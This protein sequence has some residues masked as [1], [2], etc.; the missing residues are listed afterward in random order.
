MEA[1]DPEISVCLTTYNRARF[2]NQTLDSLLAQTFVDFELIIADDC[3]TDETESVCI[4]YVETDRRVRYFRNETNLRMPANLNFAISQAKGKYIANLHDGDIFRADLLEKWKNALERYPSAG[5]VFNY[6]EQLDL[7]GNSV[8][9][10]HRLFETELISGRDLVKTIYERLSSPVW[11][12]VMARRAVYEEIGGFDP[13]YGP[14]ADVDMWIRI[15]FKYDVACILEPL[16]GLRAR[17]PECPYNKMRWQFA[18]SQEH[19]YCRYAEKLATVTG[20]KK[21]KLISNYFRRWDYH[22]MRLLAADV[23]HRRWQELREGVVNFLPE[24]AS[25]RL[26]KVGKLLTRVLSIPQK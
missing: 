2:L 25:P 8:G 11:G 17:E 20:L 5:F 13:A 23:Y 26:N 6:Y 18:I 14:I 21:Q 1:R 3:S 12:T 22:I 9:K 15:A 19:M 10:I 4:K 7:D 24:S 16:I